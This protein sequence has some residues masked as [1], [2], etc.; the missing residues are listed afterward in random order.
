[1]RAKRTSSVCRRTTI[2]RGEPR[3]LSGY[4]LVEAGLAPR[5]T[6]EAQS[7][8][9]NLDEGAFRAG[10]H[11]T[12]GP[13]TSIT[14]S[15]TLSSTHS[16][17]AQSPLRSPRASRPSTR[18]HTARPLHRTRRRLSIR[19]RLSLDRLRTRPSSKL[20][21]QTRQLLLRLCRM[22]LKRQKAARSIGRQRVR[23]QAG[24]A[25]SSKPTCIRHRNGPKSRSML[26]TR[27]LRIRQAPQ[28]TD[29]EVRAQP[30][31]VHRSLVTLQY[32]CRIS[33]RWQLHRIGTSRPSSRVTPSRPNLLRRR[34]HLRPLLTLVN[35]TTPLHQLLTP[36]SRPVCRKMAIRI[37]RPLVRNSSEVRG[38]RRAQIKVL[39][40][41]HQDRSPARRLRAG[42]ALHGLTRT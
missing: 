20:A 33:R 15:T 23:T 4:R 29:G 26:S 17:A 40:T 21:S 19:P 24:E 6:A 3:C 22:T 41:G 25:A 7:P 37:T 38:R 16:D 27:F 5:R 11:T 28:S 14:S 31:L 36:S 10:R 13:N 12:S 39:C 42:M 18:I 9:A 34:M 8:T 1:M 2:T 35:A 32:R 30:S